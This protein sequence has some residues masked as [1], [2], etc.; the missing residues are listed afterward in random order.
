MRRPFSKVRHAI[1][2]AG[3]TV[4]AARLTTLFDWRAGADDD[5][6]YVYAIALP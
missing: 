1:D 5:E 3:P 6:H 4:G 2:M